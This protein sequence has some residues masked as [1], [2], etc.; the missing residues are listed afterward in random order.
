[1]SNH[2]WY[3]IEYEVMNTENSDTPAPPMLFRLPIHKAIEIIKG[4]WN[5]SIEAAI[6]EVTLQRFGQDIYVTFHSGRRKWN[7]RLV[8]EVVPLADMFAIVANE[9]RKL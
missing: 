2:S 7:V 9:L 4:G 3:N 8:G 6:D 1:M 5:D